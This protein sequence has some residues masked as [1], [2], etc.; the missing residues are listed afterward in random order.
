MKYLVLLSLVF[1][2]LLSPA[3][4]Q[5]IPP[6]VPGTNECVNATSYITCSDSATW[7]DPQDCGEGLVC[8]GGQCINPHGIGPVVGCNPG[9]RECVDSTSYHVCGERAVWGP[10]EYCPSGQECSN[11][12]CMERLGCQPGT[13]E[14]VDSTSYHVCGERAVWEPTQYCGSGQTCS[15]GQCVPAPQ[16]NYHDTRCS[17]TDGNEVQRCNSQGQWQ[18]YRHCSHGCSDGACRDCTPGDTQCYDD[19]HYQTCD[20]DGEWGS[21]KSCGSGYICD[22]GDCIHSSQGP[23]S[24]T[25]DTRCSPDSNMELQKCSSGYW[26]DYIYC[27]D[28]CAYDMCVQCGTGNTQCADSTHYQ[29]CGSLGQWGAPS[30]CPAGQICSVNE[31]QAPSGDQCA[32]PGIKRCSPTNANMVQQCNEDNVYVDYLQCTQGCYDSQCAECAPGTTVCADADSYRTC[33]ADGQLSDPV[34]CGSGYSC[35]NGVCELAPVCTEGQRNCVSDSIYTCTGGQWQL[36]LHCPSDNDCM[37]S[38]GT[39]YC[40]PEAPPSPPAPSGPTGLEMLL[41]AGVVVLGAAVI[42]FILFRK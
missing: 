34:D 14:C 23:C 1:G 2:I 26:Q 17:P 42:Y 6:C 4:A 24:R 18:D 20:S 8:T 31:C 13:R 32:T 9:T 16:C 38:A 22:S 35:H 30:A 40:Q 7:G 33:S 28:G 5:L 27:P 19:T 29:T 41:G 36:L 10:T 15:D 39:A 25:G 11:G 12:Q 3:S 21:R 37:E